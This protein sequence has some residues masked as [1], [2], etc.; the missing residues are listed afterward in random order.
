M[1]SGGKGI[2]G[3]ALNRSGLYV[4]ELRLALFPERDFDNLK[5]K[6]S[7]GHGDFGLGTLN[8]VP[9]LGN[10]RRVNFLPIGLEFGQVEPSM[11]LQRDERGCIGAGKPITNVLVGGRVV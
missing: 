10:F 9:V 7:L 4:S 1:V 6:D 2:F 11:R 5:P 3:A 8:V